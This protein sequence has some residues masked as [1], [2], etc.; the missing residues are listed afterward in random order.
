MGNTSG[1]PNTGTAGFS[2]LDESDTRPVYCCG[3][4]DVS[5]MDTPASGPSTVEQVM[6]NIFTTKP[7]GIYGTTGWMPTNITA[8]SKGKDGTKFGEG[9]IFESPQ[10]LAKYPTTKYK[11]VLVDRKQG[12][13][14]IERHVPRYVGCIRAIP[15]SVM[16]YTFNVNQVEGETQLQIKLDSYPASE[17]CCA[18]PLL[19][20]FPPLWPLGVMILINA[21]LWIPCCSCVAN[22]LREKQSWQR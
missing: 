16:R 6:D 2:P 18:C 12:K 19:I 3:L 11:I 21:I 9:A 4:Q 8:S 1:A 10:I 7:P 17:P 13:V 15:A 22:P 5:F 14:I 20:C